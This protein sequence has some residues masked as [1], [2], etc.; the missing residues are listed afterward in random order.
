MRFDRDGEN[1]PTSA[2][3]TIRL[4]WRCDAAGLVA[5][6]PSDRPF[7]LTRS[8]VAGIQRYAAQWLGD[9]SSTFTHLEMGVAMSLGLGISGQPFVGADVPGFARHAT[10]ELAARWFEYAALTPFCRCHH[11]IDLP[12]HYPWSFGPEVEAIARAA[13]ELRYRLLPYLYAAFVHSSRTGAPVQRP[14]VFDFQDDPRVF[15]L[16]DQFMLGDALLSRP[17][18]ARGGR[19]HALLTCWQLDEGTP[20]RALGPSASLAL[21]RWHTCRCSCVRARCPALGR[22]PLPRWARARVIERT[23]SSH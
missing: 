19:A 16:D 20:A 17:C 2:T 15:D 4:L 18:C 10:P 8:G 7:V 9:H 1:A 5:S 3:T 21:P 6:R 13:L 11:Q 22:A 14:L 12:D 23:S